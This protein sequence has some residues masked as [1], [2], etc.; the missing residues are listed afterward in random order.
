M[1]YLIPILRGVDQFCCLCRDTETGRALGM[2]ELLISVK[3][4]WDFDVTVLLL[5]R[6]PPRGFKGHGP[7]SGWE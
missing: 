1:A 4:N 6:S 3:D 5:L 7:G 2:D